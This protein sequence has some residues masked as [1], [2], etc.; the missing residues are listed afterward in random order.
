MHRFFTAEAVRAA[1]EQR[2]GG[3]AAPSGGE[4]LKTGAVVSLSKDDAAHAA[5]VLRLEPGDSIIV[6]DGLGYEYEARLERVRPKESTAVIESGRLSP[7]EPSVELTLVQGIAKGSKMD[8]VVQKAVEVGVS[9]IVPLNS[10]RTVVR[11]DEA[12]ADARVERWQRIAYEAAKQSGRARIPSVAP[13]HS[14]DELWRRDDL[15]V[16]FV[17]WEGEGSQRLLEMVRAVVP[18]APVSAATRVQLTLII[19]P[20]GGFTPEEIDAAQRHGAHPVTLGPRILRTETAGLIAA[21][22]VLGACGELG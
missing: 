15:G 5:R 6:C 4:Q 7:A 11:L 1:L 18:A 3:S 20:E 14:W 22:L 21:A 10:D 17:P 13:V 8:F 9:R 19:G 2:T 12:K 16:V